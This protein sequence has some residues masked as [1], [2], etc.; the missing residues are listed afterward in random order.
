MAR[1][2]RDP[3]PEALL[4]PTFGRGE[5]KGEAVPRQAKNF[6]VLADLSDRSQAGDSRSSGHLPGDSTVTGNPPAGARNTERYPERSATRQHHD[7]RQCVCAGDRGERDASRQFSRHGGPGWL[8]A[9]GRE[10]WAEG[11]QH[12][13][14]TRGKAGSGGN[15]VKFGEVFGGR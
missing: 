4:F 14:R 13:K 7:D 10:P 12:Q 5:P 3:S 15:S 11:P 8:D 2:C 1:L 9:D 6:L